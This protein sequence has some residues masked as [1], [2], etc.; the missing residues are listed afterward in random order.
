MNARAA[1]LYGFGCLG[2]GA[3]TLVYTLKCSVPST[4]DQTPNAKFWTTPFQVNAR[5]KSLYGFGCLGEGAAILVCAP[6][7][8]QMEGMDEESVRAL[9]MSPLTH[10]GTKLEQISHATRLQSI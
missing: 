9:S 2:E 1:S 5:A 3:T 4:K 7:S 8:T 10:C 6:D